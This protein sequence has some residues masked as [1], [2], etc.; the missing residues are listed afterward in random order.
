[1][2]L[3]IG[4]VFLDEIYAEDACNGLLGIS[5]VA[6]FNG[7]VNTLQRATYEITYFAE[8]PSNNKADEDGFTILY[9]VDD[10]VVPQISLN[11]ADTVIHN[12][13]KPY[14]PQQVSVFDNYYAINQISISKT[15]TVNPY[16]LGVYSELY[17]AIDG[18]GNVGNKTRYIKVVDV[19]SP[20]IITSAV[21][22]C[23]G[24][25][26][27]AMSDVIVS[28][29][30]YG[31]DVLL[32]LVEIVNHNVNVWKPGLY[33]INYQVTDPS[34]NKSVVVMRPVWVQSS[35]DCQNTFSGV[36]DLTQDEAVTVYPNPSSGNVTVKVNLNVESPITISVLNVLGETVMR[37][38]I[39]SGM[40]ASA[41]LDLSNQINGVYI[42]KISSNNQETSKKIIL[43]K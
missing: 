31:E 27:W 6:G 14:S 4:S 19:E 5:K 12:V 24:K 28:D 20:R 21:N 36:T 23:V 38:E 13:N 30:Y 10:Y 29:N 17:T 32:P 8:D 22:T 2:N 40:N 26:F 41:D 15:G 1:V 18:S 37:Q 34:G 16:K 35:D 11:T 9:R 3:Q 33:Y 7:V 39:Q 25:G 42:I 43:S